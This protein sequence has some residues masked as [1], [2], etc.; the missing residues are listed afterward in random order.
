MFQIRMSYMLPDGNTINNVLEFQMKH[1][2]EET[3]DR[4]YREY[5]ICLDDGKI[6]EYNMVLTETREIYSVLS[7][8]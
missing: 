4:W 2:A 3:F 1:A 5:K 8:R 6:L 7:S